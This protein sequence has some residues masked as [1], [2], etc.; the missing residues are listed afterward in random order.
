[1]KWWSLVR[2]PPPLSCGDMPKKKNHL[3]QKFK[4]LKEQ[5]LMILINS[6]I[7]VDGFYV[8]MTHSRKSTI[9]QYRHPSISFS[10]QLF[11]L[12][13]LELYLPVILY[14]NVVYKE[15]YIYILHFSLALSKINSWQSCYWKLR[16][17]GYY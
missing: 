13:Y 14:M 7:E 12:F 5:N 2:I 3:F 1:M 8:C 10:T 17:Y 16:I 11:L 4:P 6:L 15:K 9:L